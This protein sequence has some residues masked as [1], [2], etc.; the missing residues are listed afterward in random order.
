MTKHTI[1][2]PGFERMVLGAPAADAV[3]A[4]AGR[5]NAERVF[6]LVSRQLDTTTN[7]IERVR[8]ALGDRYAASHCGIRPHVPKSDVV[9][10]ARRTLDAVGVREEHLKDVAEGTL[11]DIW[12]QTNSRPLRSAADVMT[13]LERALHGQVFQSTAQS[14]A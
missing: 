7:E 10:A 6:L 5:L 12:G 3:S 9:E 13:L 11:C 4:E 2:W 8:G 1:S 14:A